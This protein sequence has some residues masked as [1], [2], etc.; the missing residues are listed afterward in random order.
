MSDELDGRSMNRSQSLVGH[1]R[2]R[3][4]ALACF[5]STAAFALLAFP[6]LGGSTH[7][8]R[9]KRGGNYE[10]QSTQVL[11]VEIHVGKSGKKVYGDFVEMLVCETGQP[12]M[13]SDNQG[14]FSPE[15]SFDAKLRHR[16]SFKESD[17]DDEDLPDDSSYGSGNLTGHFVDRVSGKFYSARHRTYRRVKGKFHTHLTIKDGNGKAVHECDT[18]TDFSGHPHP[19]SIRFKAKLQRH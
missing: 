3:R 19:G 16:R 18:N 10:G 12:Y 7:P 1:R 8:P 6:A 13:Y 2:L 9:P 17:S 5:V 15:F 4:G 14:P 11:P